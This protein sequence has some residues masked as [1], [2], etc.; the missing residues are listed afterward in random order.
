MTSEVLFVYAPNR[1]VYEQWLRDYGLA[2]SNVQFEPICGDDSP[3]T[4]IDQCKE[5]P[6]ERSYYTVLDDDIGDD[7]VDWREGSVLEALSC[8]TY[9]PRI[10][11][12]TA[13]KRSGRLV[14]P[15]PS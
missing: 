1:L 13:I 15:S 8:Y 10:S 4:A 14:S 6:I 9:A 5:F 3:L 2:L 7:E 11:I 12:E